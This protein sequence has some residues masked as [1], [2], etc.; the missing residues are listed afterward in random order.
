MTKIVSETR[1]NS[2]AKGLFQTGQV[3]MSRKDARRMRQSYTR[4]SVGRFVSSW[5][6]LSLG[7]ASCYVAMFYVPSLINVKKALAISTPESQSA[8]L[9]HRKDNVLTPYLKMFEMKRAYMR[10]GQSLN[11]QYNLPRGQQLDLEIV[12]CR[13]A[14]VVEVFRCD[15]V[16]VQ[17]ISLA[18][19]TG[20]HQIRIPE[21]GFYHF[22]EVGSATD[23]RVVWKRA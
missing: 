19:G 2:K 8:R 23:Y 5:A 7:L 6:A 11:A 10:A 20:A 14:V 9:D 13:S 17:R 15:P 12:K 4:K 18:A 22:Q 21:S 3:K 16:G 1:R